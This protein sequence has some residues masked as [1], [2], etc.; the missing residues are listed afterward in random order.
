MKAKAR[1]DVASRDPAE[2]QP[3]SSRDPAESQPR[4]SRE[5]AEG[6]A[7]DEGERGPTSCEQGMLQE[8]SGSLVD[9]LSS[10][11]RGPARQPLDERRARAGGAT[12]RL[13]LGC[14]SAAP[15]LHL[16]CFSQAERQSDP[17]SHAIVAEPAAG[18]DTSA[19]RP[20]RVR[21]MSHR[22]SSRRRGRSP[23]CGQVRAWMC[24][25]TC[26]TADVSKSRPIGA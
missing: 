26:P 16:G 20:G 23:M 17:H 11:E 2:I 22:C 21:D 10:G 4:D 19:T 6:R 18:T 5:P 8:L 14:T 15:R 13:H 9:C 25:E 24:S 3:R 12:L 7:R 1:R